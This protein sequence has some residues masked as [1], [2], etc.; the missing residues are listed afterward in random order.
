MKLWKN[1]PYCRLCV[2]LCLLLLFVPDAGA[3]SRIFDREHHLLTVIDGDTIQFGGVTYDLYGIDAPELGQICL[4]DGSPWHCGLDALYALHK[5]F[6][7]DRPDCSPV[8]KTANAGNKH[9]R[10]TC[11][12]GSIPAAVMLLENG[13]AT[14][15]ADAPVGYRAAEKQARGERLGIWRG[16]YIRPQKW[17]GGE[18]LKEEAAHAPRCPVKAV[19]TAKG[20]RVY[21]VPLDAEFSSVRVEK[22]NGDKCFGSDDAARGAGYERISA[23]E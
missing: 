12:T 5:R 11:L 19:T 8:E 23:V 17:R 18:R 21:Y 22:A 2:A 7:F 3:S 10:I 14:A 9:R 13:Y 6:A 4:N 16:E 20:N 1:L 15:L